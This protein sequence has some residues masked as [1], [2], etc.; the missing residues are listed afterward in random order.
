MKRTACWLLS[1]ILHVT[2]L[3]VLL[4]TAHMESPESREIM[5]V[6]LTEHPVEAPKSALSAPPPVKPPPRPETPEPEIVEPES[7]SEPAPLP[8]D[9][10]IVLDDAPPPSPSGPKAADSGPSP[11][12]SD[13]A[14]P[15]KA[16]PKPVSKVINIKTLLQAQRDSQPSMPAKTVKKAE[17]KKQGRINIREDDVLAHRGADARFGRVM[18]SD[19]Y[20]YEATQFSG[21]FSA[22]DGRVITI[23]DARN[24]RY[25]RFLIYDSKHK[26]LRRLKETGRY[27]FTIGP[28]LYEDEPVVGSLIFA[29]KNDRIERFVLVTDDDRVAHFPHKIHVREEEQTISA[30]HGE[31]DVEISLPPAGDDF[32][33]VVF[34]QGNQCMDRG[35]VR[36]FTRALSS[37]G[38]G[39]L[40]CNVQG[41]DADTP[42]PGAGFRMATDIRAAWRYLADQPETRSDQVGLWG[43]GQGVPCAITAATEEGK[44]SPAFVICL[45]NDS[46]T[47]GQLPARHMIASMDMPVLWLITGRDTERWKDVINTLEKLRDESGK[48]FTIVLAPYRGSGEIT[49]A[50]SDASFIM[51]QVADEHARLA[52]SW[53]RS[54]HKR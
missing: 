10:T 25:G 39:A 28:S 2:C 9:E 4:Q 15:V 51:E 21:R 19:Y 22:R 38:I 11:A 14:S 54:H 36:G 41:C 47:P 50:R 24:T 7:R 30:R 17:S 34:S 48:R 31:L 49:K 45:L 18:L 16:Q 52:I 29:A 20:S 33:G 8:M 6:V 35:L 27:I 37:Q 32:P 44:R 12:P 13:S 23:I 42:K 1:I 5:E 26:T 43:N 3:T 46:L 40:I 53:I